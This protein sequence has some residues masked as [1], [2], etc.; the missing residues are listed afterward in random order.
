MVKTVD[1]Q[2]NQSWQFAGYFLL[3]LAALSTTVVLLPESRPYFRR[4]LGGPNPILVVIVASGS[5]A[6]ALWL[7]YS[8]Y[9]F[10]ILKGRATLR[11][12]ALSAG[13]ATLFAVAIIIADFFIR[14]PENMNVP[15]PQALLFYPAI[16]F[17]AEIVFH[18]LPLTLLLLVLS[19]LAGRLGAERVVW[20]AIF[21]VAAAEPTFQV[22]FEGRP[23][24]WGAAYTW[25][26][27]F[28]IALAQLIIFRRYDF[29]TMFAFRMFYYAYW[30]IAWGV[31]RLHVLF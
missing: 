24:T 18:I 28:G 13:I 4:F 3:S 25:V 19:P 6:A 11:G 23:F 29:T 14:Y 22:V 10:T 2:L 7:L 16:G 8:R 27:V 17:V 20:L 26:H 5:G 12:M 9:G 21:L 15:V 30:H 31:V 1:R